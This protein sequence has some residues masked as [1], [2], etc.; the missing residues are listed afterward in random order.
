MEPKKIVVACMEP[1]V[2]QEWTTHKKSKRIPKRLLRN[3]LVFAAVSLCLCL[4]AGVYISMPEKTEAVMSHL[5]AG[6]EYDETLGRLQYVSSILPESAMVFMDSGSLQ[7]TGNIVSYDAQTIH[8]WSAEEPW[9]EYKTTGDVFACQDGEIVTVVE[10]GRDSY[11]VRMIHTGGYE[12]VYS[13]IGDVYAEEGDY[14]YAG[15]Q[16]GIA[17]GEASFELRKDGLSIQPVFAQSE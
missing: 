11:T 12:S 16:L 1:R 3:T 8:P 13:G 7:E 5:S 10:N 17:D 2:K 4:G 15:E 9:L 14:V 6:F